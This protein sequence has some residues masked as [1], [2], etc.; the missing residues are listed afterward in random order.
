MDHDSQQMGM[1]VDS[2]LPVVT[3]WSDETQ[4]ASVQ[5]KYYPCISNTSVCVT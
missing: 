2:A 1:A 3:E 4:D 5:I